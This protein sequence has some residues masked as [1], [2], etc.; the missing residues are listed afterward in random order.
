[1][2]IYIHNICMYIHTHI[3]IWWASLVL[4]LVKNPTA[5]QVTLVDSWVGKIHWRRDRLPTAVFLGFSGGSAGKESA[6]KVG[7]LCSIPGLGRSPGEGNDHPL[8]YSGLEIP[9]VSDQIRSDAQSCPTLCNPMNR[10]T[11]GLLVH[12]HLPEFVQTHVY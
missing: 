11:P 2:Y 9:C 3:Y 4:Q 6:C 1:M 10:S 7:D 5:M 12:H 8:Q